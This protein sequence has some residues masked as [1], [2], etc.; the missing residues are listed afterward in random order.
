MDGIALRRESFG[1][2]PTRRK[3]R[4]AASESEGFARQERNPRMDRATP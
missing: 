2:R 1:R 3:E 4:D